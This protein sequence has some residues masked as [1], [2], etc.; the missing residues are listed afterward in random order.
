[1]Q[2]NRLSSSCRRSGLVGSLLLAGVVSSCLAGCTLGSQDVRSTRSSGST[3]P[4]QDASEQGGEVV[5]V[6]KTPGTA[7]AVAEPEIIDEGTPEPPPAVESTRPPVRT[8]TPAAKVEPIV[9]T[10]T[11]RAITVLLD[12]T[13]SEW[14]LLRANALE[15]LAVRPDLLRPRTAEGLADDNR[16]V[17]FVAAMTCGEVQFDSMDA[18][19]EPL[20]EDP[21]DSVRAAAIYALSRCGQSVSPAP[22]AGFVSSNDPEVRAN[23]IV[24]LGLLGDPSARP[25]IRS[26]LGQGMT[27]VD[28]TRIRLV[29]L[30]GAAAL[31]RLGDSQ[32][33]EPIRAALFAPT[34]QAELTGLA[35]QLLGQLGDEGARQMLVRLVEAPSRESRPPEIRLAAAQAIAVLG[36]RE[37]GPLLRLASEYIDS[38]QAAIRAQVASLLGEVDDATARGFL[39]D[40]MED[41]NPVVR[42]SAAGSCLKLGVDERTAAASVH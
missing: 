31:V 19:L 10:P 23:A 7:V 40:L 35:I 33:I 2:R 12:A 13:E 15:M 8:E 22:L 9:S 42:V 17:R 29:D 21:S 37:P 14:P 34:E 27:L 4:I 3:V 11:E 26:M 28:P 39:S 6:V 1:M 25:L 24:V 18:L 32:E 16:G 5:E 41:P 36:A 30:Q 38:P 20:L